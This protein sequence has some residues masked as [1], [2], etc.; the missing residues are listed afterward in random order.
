M[1]EH[2]VSVFPD[3][4]AL[5]SGIA[6]WLVKLA[7]ESSGNFAVCLSGGTT[8]KRLYQLLASGRYAAAIPWARVHLF[9]GDERFVPRDNPD[10]NYRMVNEA[11]LRH[12][13]IP[14]GNVHG[15]P[16][17]GTPEQAAAQY[18]ET[19]QGYYGAT[20]LDP[21]RLLF[22]VTFL[23]I[24]EDGHTAS[25]FPGTRVLEERRAWA[26]SV[27]G[28]KPEPRLTLTYPVLA[29]S[30]AVAFLAE[31]A[32]KQDIVERVMAGDAS[33]PASRIA[34]LGSLH[35]FLDNAAAG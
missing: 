8:P 28:A 21:S 18:Q 30:R 2:G 14:P 12:V 6:D 29:S 10:S 33:L 17:D 26:A 9:W 27:V 25:L 35:F 13:P 7:V 31:G 15:M 11:L 32:G 5:A 1:A 23:G 22:D 34:P 20:T 19:L 16:V 4:Q 24:G 3:P